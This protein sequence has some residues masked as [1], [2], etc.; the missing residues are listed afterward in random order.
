MQYTIIFSGFFIIWD[1]WWKE[2]DEEKAAAA[3][4]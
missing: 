4:A 1:C 3:A 2:V